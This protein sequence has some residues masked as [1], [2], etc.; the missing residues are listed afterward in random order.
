MKHQQIIG[1]VDTGYRR[2]ARYSSAHQFAFKETLKCAAAFDFLGM[3]DP[4][5][6]QEL[7]LEQTGSIT[8]LNG[9][10][11]AKGLA[12]SHSHAHRRRRWVSTTEQRCSKHQRADGK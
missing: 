4:P 12:V 2:G 3:A 8:I 1:E 5:K 7:N 9:A 6:D 11:T 10:R